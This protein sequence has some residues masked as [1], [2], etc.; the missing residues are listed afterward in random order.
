MQQ[1]VQRRSQCRLPS[2]VGGSSR[3]S[4]TAIKKHKML[5]V[6]HY[7]DNAKDNEGDLDETRI[8]NKRPLDQK[9]S[10]LWQ[11]FCHRG[12]NQ[13][14]QLIYRSK[15]GHTLYTC[16]WHNPRSIDDLFIIMAS[17]ISYLCK[18]TQQIHA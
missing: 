3:L 4:L 11:T 13:C 14:R 10:G 8:I 1:V 12:E 16:P 9:D 2:A 15:K 17:S 6:Y 5:C 18:Q 7:L